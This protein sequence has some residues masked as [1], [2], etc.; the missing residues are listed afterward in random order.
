MIGAIDSARAKSEKSRHADWLPR[1]A[2]LARRVSRDAVAAQVR[3]HLVR[4]LDPVRERPSRSVSVD[5]Q[6]RLHELWWLS[7]RSLG[8]RAPHALRTRDLVRSVDH[9]VRPRR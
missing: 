5:D 8:W 7:R 3:A 2:S 4:A 1:R 6:A 9:E